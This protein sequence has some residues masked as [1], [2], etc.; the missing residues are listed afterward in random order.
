MSWICSARSRVSNRTGSPLRRA[1]GAL[2]STVTAP[3]RA[4][5]AACQTASAPEPGIPCCTIR[6]AN[7]PAPFG[8]STRAGTRPP[9]AL[10]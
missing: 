5:S 3:S 7:G 10:A 1:N 9:F 2:I 8:T 4:R 6:P